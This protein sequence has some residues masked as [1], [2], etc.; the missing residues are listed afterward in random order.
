MPLAGES[1]LQHTLYQANAIMEKIV[2]Q[3]L[4]VVFS[5]DKG[6]TLSSLSSAVFNNKTK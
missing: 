5:G 1:R 4:F 3:G 2:A 6:F